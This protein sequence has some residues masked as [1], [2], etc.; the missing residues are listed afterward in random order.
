MADEAPLEPDR[1]IIDPHLHL[2]DAGG[3]RFFA[4]EAALTIAASGHAVTHT[5]FVECRAMHRSAGPEA[6]RPVGETEFAAGQA[7]I[8]E[9]GNYGPARLAHRI[10]GTA[11]LL[12]GAR[13]APVLEA[14]IAA[15]G[16]RFRG[17][18]K[19]SAWRAQ[20]MF[21]MPAD[22][23]GAGLMARPAYV[24]GA[25]VLAAM[26][27]SLDV[28]CFHSQL[29]EVIALAD[30]VPDLAIVLDHLGTPD[31]PE[32]RADWERDLR[33][34]AR[35]QN[36]AIKLGG[37]GMDINRPFDTPHRQA[38]SAALAEAWR[39]WLEATIAIFGPTRAMFESNYPPDG[40][41]GSYGAIWNAFKRIAAPFSDHEKDALFRRT[42]ARVYR[43]ALED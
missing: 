1:P 16:G 13:V 31:G 9:S 34:L 28:W 37:L 21:G 22:P 25:R 42:A 43:I 18:R 24:E 10:V 2:W 5:V 11:D 17:V 41:A 19:A 29:H 12:L 8:S 38:G 30:A 7:A 3:A 36:V 4:P 40:A 6:L 20:G 35:R 26:D 14:H 15:G 39:P 27:L 32:T 33:E 23:A